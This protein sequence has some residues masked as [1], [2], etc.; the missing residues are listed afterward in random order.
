[1]P[2]RPTTG[3]VYNST[4]MLADPEAS[5]EKIRTDGGVV[6][7]PS[8]MCWMVVSKEAAIAALKNDN[9]KVYDLCNAFNTI[10]DKSGEKLDDLIRICKWIPFL[11]DGDRHQQLRSLFAR[12]LSDI[13]DD[14]LLAIDSA[15]KRLLTH[16]QTRGGGDF[17]KEYADRLHIEAIGA[18]AGFNEADVKWIAQNSG[19][20]GGVDFAASLSEMKNA[21]QRVNNLFDLIGKLASN[22]AF[23]VKIGKHLSSVGITDTHSNRVECFT[24]LTLLGRD[25]LSGTLTLS[26]ANLLDQH[27]G[28]LVSSDWNKLTG[29]T[30]ETIRLSST[31]QLV[32]RLATKPF[33]LCGVEIASDEMVII[34]L[35]A[36][37]RDPDSYPCPHIHSPEN[38]DNIAF[39]ASRHLCV[40]MPISQSVIKIS[41]QHLAAVEYIATMPGR[42]LGIGKN[43]RKY[44]ALPIKMRK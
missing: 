3:Y 6:W 13:R 17:A 32:S 8:L 44:D 4:E 34:F 14:Y 27:D 28:I 19:S 7:S 33:N 25:T 10:T 37:N 42:K 2:P 38:G 40:G 9:L 22:S 36:A 26:L 24:A 23:F 1:M 11:C 35:P 5:F 43:T 16:M 39:G 29:L 30:D 41:M 15:S 21:N 31:V 18:L 20:H 12:I